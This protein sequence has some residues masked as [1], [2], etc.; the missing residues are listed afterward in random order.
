MNDIFSNQSLQPTSIELSM[1]SVG[2]SG[3]QPQCDHCNK[4]AEFTL[5]GLT[6]MRPVSTEL[7]G[8]HLSEATGIVPDNSGSPADSPAAEASEVK[9]IAGSGQHLSSAHLVGI[10]LELLRQEDPHDWHR[11]VTGYLGKDVHSLPRLTIAR[12]NVALVRRRNFSVV[13]DLHLV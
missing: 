12:N 8:E 9:P 2:G 5:T 11:P 6:N 13:I 3:V 1:P 10:R 7:C 4:A